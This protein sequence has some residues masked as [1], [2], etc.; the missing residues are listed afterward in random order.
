MV[1][2]VSSM[3]EWKLFFA[4]IIVAA[5]FV[6]S[7]CASVNSVQP[8]AAEIRAATQVQ[9]DDF[10]CEEVELGQQFSDSLAQELRKSE[11]FTEVIR[12]GEL[13]KGIVVYGRIR[14]FRKGSVPA[15][16]KF[17]PA[18]GNARLAVEVSVTKAGTGEVLS[19]FSVDEST[20]L[21]GPDAGRTGRESFDWLV[22]EVSN[23]VARKLLD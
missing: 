9:V 16:I 23:Q 10:E 19:S 3:K 17:G 15:R 12:T 5:S 21:T 22:K 11:Q 20:L 7:G 1:F 8:I 2:V 4:K 18:V 6:L 13:D 14:D